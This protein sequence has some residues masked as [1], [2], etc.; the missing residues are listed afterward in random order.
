[1]SALRN[2][3][4]G[5]PLATVSSVGFNVLSV[6][7]SGTRINEDLA[8]ICISGG[9]YPEGGEST[10]LLWAADVKLMP[11]QVLEVQ[12]LEQADNS[13]AGKTIDEY[14]PNEPLLDLEEDFTPTPENFAKL[15][16][17]PAYRNEFSLSFVSSTGPV[18][19]VITKKDDH[20]FAFSVVWDSTRPLDA[21]ASMHSYTIEGLEN[22]SNGNYHAQEELSFGDTVKLK[23]SAS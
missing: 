10:Y 15:K 9:S 7:V 17:Q 16:A 1:M 3:I 4:D 8:E 2:L 23:V 14:F 19:K 22:R 20:G 6:Y 5:V 12:F 18:V 13:H 11:H 21:R